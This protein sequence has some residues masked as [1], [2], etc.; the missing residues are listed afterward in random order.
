M[1]LS[2]ISLAYFLPI[3]NISASFN[4]FSD[5]RSKLFSWA[6]RADAVA[7]TPR[8]GFLMAAVDARFL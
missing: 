8:G 3:F 5:C 6:I 7:I 2:V 4:S 1:S